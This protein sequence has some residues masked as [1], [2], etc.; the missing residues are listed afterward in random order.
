MNGR[1]HSR[2]LFLLS[3]SVLL[4]SDPPTIMTIDFYRG[5]PDE[6]HVYLHLGVMSALS[7]LMS[8]P[9]VPV[10]ALRLTIRTATTALASDHAFPSSFPSESV[11]PITSWSS[12]LGENRLIELSP[13]FLLIYPCIMYPIDFAKDK[14]LSFLYLHKALLSSKPVQ[15]TSVELPRSCS[16][17]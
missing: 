9:T 5:R 6:V 15:N 2:Y 10:T 3:P 4:P 8:F 7:R 17:S 12:P 13:S 11:F 1:A 16:W 14:S